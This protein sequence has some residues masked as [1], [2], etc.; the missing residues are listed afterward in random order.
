LKIKAIKRFPISLVKDDPK[1]KNALMASPVSEGVMVKIYTDNNIS[2]VG[3]AAVPPYRGVPADILTAILDAYIP[4]LIGKDPFNIESILA[5][6]DEIPLDSIKKPFDIERARMSVKSPID[7]AFHDI[8]AK[9]L[10][11]PVYRLLGGLV[12]EEVPIL[13]IMAI[14]EP[15]DMAKNA[16]GL[17]KEGTRYLKIKLEGNVVKDVARVKA[18][19]EAVGPKVHLTLDPNQSYAPDGA[20]EALKLMEPYQIDI[21][22]QPVAAD[23]LK[24]LAKVTRSVKCLVEAHESAYSVESV[25]D[26]VKDHVASCI[27]VPVTE[28][29]LREARK[30]MDICTVGKVHCLV[31][32]VGSQI[33]SAACMHFVASAKKIDYACQLGE[34][35]RFPND[36]ASGL[37]IKNGMLRVPHGPGLGIEV[38]LD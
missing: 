13:R 37:E 2:G 4:Y 14:K 3:Y 29:G 7:I 26:L 6:I 33:Y 23:D 12:R 22:E 34:F 1:W 21:C 31:A 25:F 16:L 9:S 38:N 15:A 17:V 8:M 30:I 27:S 36:P 19:R 20:I 28:G 10:N 32:C 5:G 35:V 11:M 18:V 24:G